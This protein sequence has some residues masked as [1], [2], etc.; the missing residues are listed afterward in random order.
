MKILIGKTTSGIT[1]PKYLTQED[2][3][4]VHITGLSQSGKSTFLLHVLKELIKYRKGF[5]L[6][7]PHGEL[8]RQFIAFLALLDSTAPV[9][10]FDP[11]YEK[12]IVGF[13]PFISPYIDEARLMT[14]ASR[15]CTATLRVFGLSSS[16]YY[17]N[18]ERWL[19]CIYYTLLELGL[20]I[21][22]LDT[23]LYWE[24]QEE[25]DNLLGR[26]K[27][28]AVRNELKEFYSVSR[29]EFK[30][31]L[32]STRNKL[33][34]FTH[35]QAKRILGLKTNNLDLQAIV[36][37][38]QILLC[39]LQPAEDDLIGSTETNLLGTLLINELWELTRKRRQKVDYYFIVDECHQYV[40]QDVKSILAEAAKYGLRVW[41]S[42]QEMSQVKEIEGA[43]KNART[44]IAFGQ[45]KHFTLTRANG[46][47]IQI[48]A[49]DVKKWVVPEQKVEEY[50]EAKTAEFLTTREV[51]QLLYRPHDE[52]K[53][54]KNFPDDDLTYE[55]LLR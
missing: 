35:P 36:D 20:T 53:E 51:D 30:K 48:E 29:Q 33:Q 43:I 45:T 5:C 50:Q 55:D 6:I 31:D 15:M 47:V 17:G 39:N 10:L 4:H 13:N 44:K 28:Q 1:L 40:G 34:R 26:L 41:L 9:H 22:S 19:R 8:Y 23:F 32:Q 21:T 27:S 52:K 7:D 42:H 18:V 3:P 54:H 16:D 14:K 37:K 11:S 2:H 24:K 25:R 38:G 49:P 46:E 12:R